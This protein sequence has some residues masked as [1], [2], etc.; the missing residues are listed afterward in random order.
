M[1]K[2]IGA[3]WAGLTLLIIPLRWYNER[4]YEISKK[5]RVYRMGPPKNQSN[6]EKARMSAYVN[7]ILENVIPS[8]HFNDKPHVSREKTKTI[9]EWYKSQRPLIVPF[10]YFCSRICKGK[11]ETDRLYKLEEKCKDKLT[12]HL[13]LKH[14]IEA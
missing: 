14:L 6:E 3:L 8:S 4:R 1:V 13:D 7:S 9:L 2:K 5:K 11:S 12:E 10:F